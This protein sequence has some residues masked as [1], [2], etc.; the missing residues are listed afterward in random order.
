MVCTIPD[1]LLKGTTNLR[2]VRTLRELNPQARIIAVSETLAEVGALR[3]A[4]AD[5]V[6]VPRLAEAAELWSVVR[7]AE[8]GSLAALRAT[9]EQRLQGRT[10]VLP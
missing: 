2:L 1:S 4:G 7:E 9:A 6:S 10:E 3:A 8:R 5:Y